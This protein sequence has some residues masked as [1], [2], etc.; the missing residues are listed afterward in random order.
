MLRLTLSEIKNF[1]LRRNDE[2]AIEVNGQLV[3]YSEILRP[4]SVL[5]DNSDPTTAQVKLI[6]K[7]PISLKVIAQIKAL[8]GNIL[9]LVKLYHLCLITFNLSGLLKLP[10]K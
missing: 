10:K 3:K 8:P 6:G 7:G 1:E 2:I 9:Q 5:I 4:F